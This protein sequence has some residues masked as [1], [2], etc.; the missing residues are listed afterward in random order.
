MEHHFVRKDC[1]K[2]SDVMEETALKKEEMPRYVI[3][4]QQDQFNTLM[5]LLKRN[6]E[7]SPD[8]WNLIRSLYTNQE[9]YR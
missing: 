8:V 6:D 1:K 4:A 5:N 9:L 3:S 2:M 7:T